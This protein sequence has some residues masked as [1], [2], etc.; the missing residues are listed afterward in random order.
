MNAQPKAPVGQ[1]L[2]GLL[3]LLIALGLATLAYPTSDDAMSFLIIAGASA[4]G[5]ILAL[6]RFTSLSKGLIGSSAFTIL[7][8]GFFQL[9]SP[10]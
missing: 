7:F 8:V 10:P 6:M 3:L 4:V 5:A 2:A 9:Q 1:E